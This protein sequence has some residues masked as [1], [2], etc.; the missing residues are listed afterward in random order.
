M[1]VEGKGGEMG[2]GCNIMWI[3]GGGMKKDWGGDIRREEGDV[4]VKYVEEDLGNE[5]VG[6]DR[7]VE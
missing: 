1:G 5:G 6:L 2:M 3:E 4:V 7:G